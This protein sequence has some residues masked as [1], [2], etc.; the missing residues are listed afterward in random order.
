MEIIAYHSGG[1]K[2]TVKALADSVLVRMWYLQ[3]RS[4]EVLTERRDHNQ[5]PCGLVNKINNAFTR[6]PTLQSTIL[7]KA[8]S[9]HT[10]AL[11]GFQHN[12]SENLTIQNRND[13]Y[14]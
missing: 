14:L 13:I 12:D 11:L 4:S 8:P 9:S 2:F 6:S 10:I 5:V 1:L 3:M 7:G